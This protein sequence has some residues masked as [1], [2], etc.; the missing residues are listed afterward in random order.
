MFLP[1]YLC[2][3]ENMNLSSILPISLAG[4][5]ICFLALTGNGATL[6]VYVMTGTKQNTQ[7]KDS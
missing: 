1:Y 3:A 2:A 6:L 7:T 5:I 4:N